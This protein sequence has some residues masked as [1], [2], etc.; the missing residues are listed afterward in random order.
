M[1]LHL[2]QVLRLL[3]KYYI[4]DKQLYLNEILQRHCFLILFCPNAVTISSKVGTILSISSA[5][6]VLGG[7]PHLK[8]EVPYPLPK[9]IA[10]V[11]CIASNLSASVMPSVDSIFFKSDTSSGY[12]LYPF[13]PNFSGSI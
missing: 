1:V 10:F 4:F 9:V 8:E 13:P 2:L 6:N 5:L 3:S 11:F 7:I 12:F